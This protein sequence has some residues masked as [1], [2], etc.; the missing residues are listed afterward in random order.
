VFDA[1]VVDE[2]VKRVQDACGAPVGASTGAWIKPNPYRRADH[3]DAW[4]SP[5][6]ASVNLSE[7]GA[8]EVMRAC[9]RA[10]VGIDAGVWSVQDVE[11]LAGSGFA[12]KLCT[13]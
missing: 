13:C 7:P 8:L 5:D 9:Q 6:F 2:T 4:Q 11:L 10:G 12:G 1:S 3:I